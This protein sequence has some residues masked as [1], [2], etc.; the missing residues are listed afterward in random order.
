MADPLGA[1][2]DRPPVSKLKV[3][4][5]VTK[6]IAIAVGLIATVLCLSSLIGALT[7]NVWVRLGVAAAVALIPP[8]VAIERILPDDPKKGK[9][10]PTDLLAI[11]W[12]VIPLLYAGAAH[13][14]TAGLLTREAERL[15][16]GLFS[17][18]AAWMASVRT[19]AS[20]P[21]DRPGV[22][23]ASDGGMADGRPDAGRDAAVDRAARGTRD[24]SVPRDAPPD[25]R[26][27]QSP[28][29]ELS[30]A[31]IFER[32]A[33]SV[34]TVEVSSGGD[35]FSGGGTGFLID[36]TGTIAT[37]E[38]VIHGAARV[39]IKLFDGTLID[40]VDLLVAD[41]SNDLALM[42][43]P[44]RAPLRP[45]VLGNSDAVTVGERV[46]AIGNPLGLEHTLTD[47]LISARR[48]YEGRAFIQ[49]SAPI[50]PGNSGG[51]LFNLRGEVIGITTAKVG[52]GSFGRAENLNLATPINLLRAMVRE[53]YPGRH[54]FGESA[55]SSAGRW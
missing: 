45:A 28:L 34:V 12:L 53:S 46:V 30:P 50:S 31:Q 18:G 44:L 51:P 16:P 32:Y 33:Q 17:W 54:R 43:V 29:S 39:R 15:G 8:I 9:G 3:A 20:S 52:G 21:D 42:R 26:P 48:I 7:G 23:A 40:E 47:G 27:S 19:E 41:A 13:G 5:G 37:N 1:S 25:M 38:H 14:W 4:Y 6:A 36:A 2:N 10:I 22:A 55:G 35:S 11:L 24:A 49:T